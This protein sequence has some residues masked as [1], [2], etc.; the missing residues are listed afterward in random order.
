MCPVSFHGGTGNSGSRD[1]VLQSGEPAT[2]EVWSVVFNGWMG[3]TMALSLRLPAPVRS[4]CRPLGFHGLSFRLM[5]L[6]WLIL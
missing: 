5:A 6:D 1:L 2:G 3:P 4:L